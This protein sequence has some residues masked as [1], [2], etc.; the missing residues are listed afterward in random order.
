LARKTTIKA[1]EEWIDEEKVDGVIAMISGGMTLREVSLALKQP[2]TCLQ[3]HLRST[4]EL[5]ERYNQ[6]LKD[7]ADAVE[8]ENKEI[9]DNVLADRDEVAK[10]KLQ[11]EVRRGHAK[12]LNRERWGEHVQVEKSITVGADTALLGKAADLLHRLTQKTEK[13]IEG[14]ELVVEGTP[15]A[16]TA[17]RPPSD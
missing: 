2:Y 16:L 12:A 8:G 3:S 13:V 7:Y 5:I 11:I 15:P 14:A 17:A 6:A 4:P 10:A 1:F 9:A